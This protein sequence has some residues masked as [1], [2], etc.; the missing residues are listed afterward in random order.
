MGNKV[1]MSLVEA[2]GI[3]ESCGSFVV[4]SGFSSRGARAQL[5]GSMWDRSSP[6]RGWT[7]TA[8]IGST[9]LN[10]WITREVLTKSRSSSEQNQR[11]QWLPSWKMHWVLKPNKTFSCVYVKQLGLVSEHLKPLFIDTNVHWDVSKSLRM[12]TSLCD[13]D[14]LLHHV[15]CPPAQPLWCPETPQYV[16]GVAPIP[17]PTNPCTFPGCPLG[18]SIAHLW[19]DV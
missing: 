11:P 19:R 17:V 14:R 18:G 2:L 9:S 8:C 16:A 13:T 5:L 7:Q 10:H 15:W 12:W 3:F 4:P 1:E 6:T